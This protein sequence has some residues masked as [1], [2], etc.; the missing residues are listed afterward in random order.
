MGLFRMST[1]AGVTAPSAAAPVPDANRS[2][3]RAPFA[4][5][6]ATL[7]VL[8]NYTAPAAVLP[9]TARSLGAGLTTQTWLINAIT[10]GLAATLLVAGSLGDDFG[11]RRIFRAG[12]A[13]LIAA[14]HHGDPRVGGPSGTRDRRAHRGG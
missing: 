2:D 13:L 12:L 10:L 3:S 9:Q 6:A 8:M 11:R 5:C 7:L 4:V 1:P 14:V